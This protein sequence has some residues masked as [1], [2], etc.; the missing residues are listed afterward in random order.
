MRSASSISRFLNH[1]NWP[2]RTLLKLTRRALLKWIPDSNKGRAKPDL[3]VLIDLTCLEKRG[4]FKVSGSLI[5]T[6]YAQTGLHLVVLYLD[7][8][9][10]RV[11][12]GFR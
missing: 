3:N 2:T 10:A 12:W 9:R 4:R 5:D 8:G 1:Y 6:M 7:F 11:P